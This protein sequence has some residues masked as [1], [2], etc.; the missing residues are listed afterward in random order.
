MGTHRLCDAENSLP[1]SNKRI[2]DTLCLYMAMTRA[3]QHLVLPY[4][5]QPPAALKQALNQG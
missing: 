4:V 1:L 5:G 2:C 3:D